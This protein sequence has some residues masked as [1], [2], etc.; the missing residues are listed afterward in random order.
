MITEGQLL[1]F[2]SM[3]DDAVFVKNLVWTL[4]TVLAMNELGAQKLGTE[5][6]KSA[7]EHFRIVLLTVLTS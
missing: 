4:G 6:C 2:L 3:N 7:Q 5:L 1:Q